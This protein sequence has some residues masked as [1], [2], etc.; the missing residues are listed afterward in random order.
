MLNGKTLMTYLLTL[1]VGL[2]M[3]ACPD[4]E[5]GEEAG[6]EAGSEEAGNW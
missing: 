6:A 2:M 5:C 1:F 3:T 4:D